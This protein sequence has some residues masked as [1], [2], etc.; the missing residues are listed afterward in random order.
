MDI[1]SLVNWL[2][3]GLWVVAAVIYI[4]RLPFVKKRIP[5][6][7][8]FSS[9]K[10][11]GVIIVFGLIATGIS[12]YLN[13]RERPWEYRRG[14]NLIEVRNRTYKNE[15]VVLDGHRYQDCV[16]EN[17]T[18]V[19]NGTADIDFSHNKIGGSRGFETSNPAV[20]G[21]LDFLKGMGYLR[22]DIPIFGPNFMPN[23]QVQSPSEIGEP[24]SP[25][26]S[27]VH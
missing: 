4:S 6:W 27:T 24:P 23:T 13:Y 22:D 14:E 26:P 16:F 1:S 19:Y 2:Q 5:K 25:S 21:T 11:I 8:V 12:F 9:N 10:A 20:S 3:L 7:G 18:F 17:V 15:K